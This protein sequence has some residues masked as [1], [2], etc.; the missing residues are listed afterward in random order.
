MLTHFFVDFIDAV[1][2][3]LGLSSP[4]GSTKKDDEASKDLSSDDPR[5]QL[6]SATLAYAA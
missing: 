6:R 2:K 5:I 4:T 3:T 1:A